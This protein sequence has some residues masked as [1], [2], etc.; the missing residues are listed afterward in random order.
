MDLV[1]LGSPQNCE[2]SHH[3]LVQGGIF[4]W[5]QMETTFL[6]SSLGDETNLRFL[7]PLCSS[8]GLSIGSLVGVCWLES[9]HSLLPWCQALM[10]LDLHSHQTS[11]PAKQGS[12]TSL[13]SSH[14]CTK[15]TE[16]LK[17]IHV[18]LD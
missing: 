7:N 16:L 17:F 1:I 4:C 5:S 12:T 14:S 18:L 8:Y 11:I 9:H 3:T 13:F 2:I 10:E 15:S 6:L